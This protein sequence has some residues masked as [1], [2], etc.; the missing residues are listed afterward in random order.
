MS[1]YDVSLSNGRRSA[2]VRVEADDF[3]EAFGFTKMTYV[4]AVVTHIEFV[5][6]GVV[7]PKG[8][9]EIDLNQEMI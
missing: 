4:N 1:L 6:E 9:R 7:R 5:G 3:E 8:F 2:V